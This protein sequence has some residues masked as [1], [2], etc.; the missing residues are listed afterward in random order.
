MARR[1]RQDALQYS[2]CR[3]RLLC[4]H[5]VSSLR[6]PSPTHHTQT[7]QHNQMARRIA[8]W[9][10]ENRQH[11]TR[12]LCITT[13]IRRN[14]YLPRLVREL[15]SPKVKSCQVRPQHPQQQ[16]ALSHRTTFDIRG[17]SFCLSATVSVR[18]HAVSQSLRP[19]CW[20]R[21]GMS[22]VLA[23][24]AT[25]SGSRGG[26]F[27]RLPG[28]GVRGGTNPTADLSRSKHL[29]S[30]ANMSLPLHPRQIPTRHTLM[31]EN[32]Q[33]ASTSKS[34]HQRLPHPNMID[35][36]YMLSFAADVAQ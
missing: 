11:R 17:R 10:T 29:A 5:Q 27:A 35:Q 9:W 22:V 16:S 20:K 15:W 3:G 13:D 21:A 36:L 32:S 18:R 33:P 1:Q 23:A 2:C 26:W 24:E 6:V 25:T 8:L 7:A 31:V 4:H 28:G 14:W 30:V 19:T 34:V 12:S